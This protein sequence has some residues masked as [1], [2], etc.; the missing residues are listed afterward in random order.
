[1]FELSLDFPSFFN[2]IGDLREG[3]DCDIRRFIPR[4]TDKCGGTIT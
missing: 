4:V 2:Y 3:M 1:M